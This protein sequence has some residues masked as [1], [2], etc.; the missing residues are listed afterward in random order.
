MDD[1]KKMFA[2]ALSVKFKENLSDIK[3]KI[4]D[5]KLSATNSFN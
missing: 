1:L 3:Y 5:H 2:D 4:Q